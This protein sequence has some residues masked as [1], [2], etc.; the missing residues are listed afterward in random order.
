MTIYKCPKCG[1]LR[2]GQPW[3]DPHERVGYCLMHR[4][5]GRAPVT[6]VEAVPIITPTVAVA[7]TSNKVSIA[8]KKRSA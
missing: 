6:V 5:S 3:K 7:V 8:F 2:T 1:S 4:R